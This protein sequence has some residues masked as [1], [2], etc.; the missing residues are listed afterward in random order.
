MTN[1]V[2]LDTAIDELK[3]ALTATNKENRDHYINNAIRFIEEAKANPVVPTIMPGDRVK[4]NFYGLGMVM[5]EA[6]KCPD[7]ILVKYDDQQYPCAQ[8]V[9]DLEVVE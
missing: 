7:E 6:R 4:H 2:K 8:F 3:Y 5:S 9:K 1:Q